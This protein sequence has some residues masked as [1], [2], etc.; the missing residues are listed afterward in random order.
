MQRMER[1][2]VQAIEAVKEDVIQPLRERVGTL[3]KLRGMSFGRWVG[4]LGVVAAFLAVVVTAWA[5]TKGGPAAPASDDACASR[6][7]GTVRSGLRLCRRAVAVAPCDGRLAECRAGRADEGDRAVVDGTGSDAQSAAGARCDAVGAAGDGDCAGRAWC[8]GGGGECWSFGESGCG[9]CDWIARCRG[10]GRGDW[11]DWTRG[12]YGSGRAGRRHGASRSGGTGRFG[13]SGR[14]AGSAW[15]ERP[16]R[17]SWRH[18]RDGSCTVFVDVDGLHGHDLHLLADCAGRD[19]V[20]LC[21]VR[22]PVA[23]TYADADSI[24]VRDGPDGAS[25]ETQ[26]DGRRDRTR[27]GGG[28][29]SAAAHPGPR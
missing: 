11:G 16:E 6:R 19:D 12:C 28:R 24:A 21:S 5:A 4:A 27:V 15:P 9:W 17:C 1:E 8:A 10:Q 29:G 25:R 26:R 2:R 23:V 7:G 22:E 14:G 3:E 18:G 20:C 13:R